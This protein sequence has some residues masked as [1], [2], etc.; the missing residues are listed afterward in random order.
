MLKCHSKN[1]TKTF[2]MLKSFCESK[3]IQFSYV[4]L[5][6]GI[7]SEVHSFE[8]IPISNETIARN[9]PQEST[10]GKTLM[11][12]LDEIDKCRPYFIGI[13]GK[14]YGWANLDGKD[15]LLNQTFDL[16]ESRF[17]F[18]N[19]YRDRSITEIEMRYST[20]E[21][22]SLLSQRYPINHHAA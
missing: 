11:I 10:G 7:T 14:R 12:C 6:W 19:Q 15:D 13:L 3:G 2:P 5:R 4:D 16:A 20:L 18:L 17:P 8:R 1:Q 9:K 22:P 21:K